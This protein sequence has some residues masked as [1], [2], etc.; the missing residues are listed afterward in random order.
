MTPRGT[1]MLGGCLNRDLFPA[2]SHQSPKNALNYQFFT[3]N[4]IRVSG[5]LRLKKCLS[6]FQN[7]GLQ[8][9]FSVNQ[10]GDNLTVPWRRSMLQNHNIATANV[11][12]NH[13]ISNDFQR[14]CR[15]CRFETDGFNIHRHTTLG[16]LFGLGAES[17]RNCSEEGNFDNFQSF[18]AF[19]I[20]NESK[21]TRFAPVRF[22]KALSLNRLQMTSSRSVASETELCGDLS[23][24]RRRASGPDGIPNKIKNFLLSLG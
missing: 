3:R 1:Q 5:M 21:R 10:R 7:V 15:A 16:F 11:A 8:R 6:L 14:E 9:A 20:V 19:G 13:R 18:F 12:A 17:R 22:Q 24:S 4:E 2:L 23:Q